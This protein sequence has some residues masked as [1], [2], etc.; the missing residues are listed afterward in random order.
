MTVLS[1]TH[2]AISLLALGD[3]LESVESLHLLIESCPAPSHRYF[4]TQ[5]QKILSFAI[6]AMERGEIPHDQGAA[7]EYLSRI[8]WQDAID[9]LAGK[10]LALAAGK[11]MGET[12]MV[13]IQAGS[14]IGEASGARMA[15]S[16]LTY[17][18]PK[19]AIRMLRH[20]ADRVAL[21]DKLA[22]TSSAL[23]KVSVTED[24]TP[25][26]AS[27][28]DLLRDTG[29]TAGERSLGDSLVQALNNSAQDAALRANGK[30]RPA[31]WGLPSLDKHLPLV[32]GRFYVVGAR[33]G[34]GKTSLAIQS[35]HCT[36][37][38]LGRRSVAYLSLEMS[39]E[40][41]ALVLACRDA[42]VPRN[43]VA[44]AWETLIEAERQA[45][46]GLA[47]EWQESGSMWLRD[48]TA[49]PQTVAH[50]GAWIRSQRA[51]HGALELVVVDYLGLIKGSNPRQMLVDRTAEITSTLKQI[52]LA[53]GVAI[54]LLSQLTREGR[55][56]PR[57]ADGKA[58]ADPV[59]RV[60]DLYGGGSIEADADGVVM[61]HP[62]QREGQERRVD[63][64][65][66]KNRRG[67]FPLTCP[68]WFY[69]KWQHFQDVEPE[70]VAHDSRSARLQ[71]A[72]DD[73]EQCF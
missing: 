58:E 17:G 23:A 64:I 71:S 61:L 15:G 20:L 5:Q 34:G 51:R 73:A 55:K 41:L 56:P 57:G 13:A 16:G 30:A 68:T 40:E 31:T 47:K 10:P 48:S 18:P 27:L 53:E 6:D 25:L 22:K 52:A 19:R 65:I 2:E 70:P 21:I 35:A 49:G 72:P 38:N 37:K 12:A 14:L 54:I 42:K 3:A 7:M 66:A 9:H 39:S 44:N 11:D 60:E 4:A 67:P 8:R 59:P 63:A 24:A 32:K 26:I 62:I 45:L 36:A 46:H 33:P 28:A 1:S 29:T 50:V 69:G 43:A